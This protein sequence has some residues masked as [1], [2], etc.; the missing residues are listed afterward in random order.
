MI[1]FSNNDAMPLLGLGTWRTTR[2]ETYNSV[3]EALKIGY[4]H[5]DCAFIYGNE[6]VIGQAFADAFAQKI[7]RREELF[8][9]SKLW[10]D[11]HEKANVRPALQATL[12]SLHLDYL[13]L[14]LMHWPVA[15]RRGTLFP[16]RP[17]E[18]LS[19]KQAPLDETWA[20]M[21]ECQQQGMCRHIGVS[22]FTQG[23]LA[24]LLQTAKQ[25]PEMNQVELHPYLQQPEL[26]EFCQKNGIHLTAYAPLGAGMSDE[27]GKTSILKNPVMLEIAQKHRSTAAQVTLA[28]GMARNTVVI[29]KSARA[30]RLAENFASQSVALDKSD[31]ASIASLN[32]NLRITT[33]AIWTM[34]GS[35]YTMNDLWGS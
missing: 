4:R 17:D 2:E 1:K 25:K 10:N 9:T 11:A 21:E 7:V 27:A 15:L 18:F 31:L 35:P 26:A 3:F 5:V 8:V 12:H 14:Y 6:D 23:K 19:L 13:D 20:A 29:P 30:H 24:A 32:Q 16:S 28:W 22:N 34:E 33:G